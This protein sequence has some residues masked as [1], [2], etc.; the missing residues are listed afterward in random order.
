MTVLSFKRFVTVP[1]GDEPFAAR[2]EI[3]LEALRRAPGAL[4]AEL[5]GLPG[6]YIIL[7]EW[8]TGADLDA[9]EGAATAQAFSRDVDVL[10]VSEPTDR[11]FEAAP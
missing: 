5:T 11:R 3:H 9:W 4:W 2:S 10:L 7:S 6:G 1:D 8:R